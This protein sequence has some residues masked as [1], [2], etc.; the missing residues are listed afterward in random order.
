MWY[1]IQEYEKKD[2]E[3]DGRSGLMQSPTTS[4]PDLMEFERFVRLYLR[5]HS[6]PY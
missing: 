4:S 6:I 2:V 5:Q 3:G 1:L